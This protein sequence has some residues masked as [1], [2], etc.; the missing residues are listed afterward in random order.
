MPITRTKLNSILFQQMEG[1]RV[2]SSTNRHKHSKIN[3]KLRKS[4]K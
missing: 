2:I 1:K 3:Q 4:N